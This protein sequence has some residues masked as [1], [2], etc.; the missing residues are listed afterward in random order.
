M[1]GCKGLSGLRCTGL[2]DDRSTLRAGLADMRTWHIIIFSNVV[3]F[4]HKGWVCVYAALAI[5]NDGI[6]APGG[7]PKLVCNFDI[8]FCQ[9]ISIIVLCHC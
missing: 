4:S 3:D 1:L 9:G 5:K 6:L 8:F 7:L 2:E